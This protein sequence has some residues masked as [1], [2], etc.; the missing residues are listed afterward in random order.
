M[1]LPWSHE[2]L[3]STQTLALET[4][5]RAHR[6]THAP[7]VLNDIDLKT[8][9][10]HGAVLAVFVVWKLFAKEMIGHV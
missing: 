9:S 3:C 6:E 8:G 7:I 2:H 10:L 1:P 5:Q 4:R